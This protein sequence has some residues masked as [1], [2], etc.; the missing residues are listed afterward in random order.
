[1]ISYSLSQI[2]KMFTSCPK[3]KR[4][5]M[6]QSNGVEHMGMVEAYEGICFRCGIFVE[7]RFGVH[8]PY[9]ISDI[10]E[11]FGNYIDII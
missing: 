2:F 5:A 7:D 1:M 9:F 8:W 11:Q 10:R 6:C 3:C 4:P